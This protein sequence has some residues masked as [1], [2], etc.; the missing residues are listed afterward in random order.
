MTLFRPKDDV[1]VL[2]RE[3]LSPCMLIPIIALMLTVVTAALASY[4]SYRY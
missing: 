3:H 2:C 1:G 4:I